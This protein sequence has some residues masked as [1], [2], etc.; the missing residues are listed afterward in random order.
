MGNSGKNCAKWKTEKLSI[1]AKEPLPARAVA[2]WDWGG[3]ESGPEIKNG[4]SVRVR[5]EFVF[6]RENGKRGKREEEPIAKTP[7]AKIVIVKIPIVKTPRGDLNHD[8]PQEK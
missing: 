2:R 5:P 6:D 3:G 7:T 8:R 4:I 1:R